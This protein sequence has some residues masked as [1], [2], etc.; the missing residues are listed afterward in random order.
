[1]ACLNESF[2]FSQPHFA[3]PVAANF[4]YAEVTISPG[5]RLIR[6]DPLPKKQTEKTK[7]EPKK[8]KEK[9][10]VKTKKTKNK[11]G[12]KKKNDKDNPQKRTQPQTKSPGLGHLLRG[13]S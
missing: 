13:E 7:K 8:E 4:G 5:V 10:K 11:E 2:A 3:S 6:K 1:M 12:K 9:K